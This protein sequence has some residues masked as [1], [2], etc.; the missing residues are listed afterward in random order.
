MLAAELVKIRS[1]RSTYW[2]LLTTPVVCAALGF[3]IGLSA[4]ASLSSGRNVSGSFDPGFITFYGITLGQIPLVVFAVL[5]VGA[6]Y[7]SGTINPS[8]TAMPRRS[9]FYAGKVLAAALVVAPVSLLSTAAIFTAAQLGLG[10]HSVTL[11][12]EG[13]TRA[14]VGAFLYLTLI[15]LLATGV[16]ATLRSSVLSLGVLLPLL[17]LGSQG[18]GNIP[19]VKIVTQ[20]LPDQAGML[21]LFT[22][23]LTGNFARPYGPWTGVAI[24]AAWTTAALLAGHVVTSRR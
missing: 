18:L 8:L 4:Q 17:F 2:T 13:M 19:G 14:A 16:A 6:E 22:A 15:P 21:I 24:L 7:S 11:T 20:Y 12:T 1:V 9:T 3:L 23:P 5:L 10:P